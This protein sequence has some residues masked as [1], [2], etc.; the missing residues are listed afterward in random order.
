MFR[1]IN[2][3][4]LGRLPAGNDFDSPAGQNVGAEIEAEMANRLARN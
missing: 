4:F 2:T 1:A 3:R